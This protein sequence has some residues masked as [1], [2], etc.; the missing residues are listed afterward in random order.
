M[1][2]ERQGPSAPQESDSYSGSNLNTA[3][4]S[5]RFSSNSSFNPSLTRA[6][7]DGNTTLGPLGRDEMGPPRGASLVVCIVGIGTPESHL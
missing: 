3:K 6:Y 2:S 5:F 1:L 7:T 4:L